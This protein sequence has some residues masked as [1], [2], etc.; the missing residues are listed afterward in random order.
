M[1][2][3]IHHCRGVDCAVGAR[4]VSL[5]WL[6]VVHGYL[7]IQADLVALHSY[8]KG[9]QES[10]YRARGFLLSGLFIPGSPCK[11]VLVDAAWHKPD[12]VSD[13]RT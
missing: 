2:S 1:A 13:F 9:I 5:M 10:G 12:L 8:I 11:R 6:L 7:S 3:G 4:P